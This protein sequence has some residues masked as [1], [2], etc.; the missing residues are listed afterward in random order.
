MAMDVTTL[1]VGGHDLHAV[2]WGGPGGSE[3]GSP[4]V[5]LVHGLGGSCIE[6]D[7]AAPLLAEALDRPVLALDLP[8]FGQSRLPSG[9]ATVLA[10]RHVVGEVM[11]E[12]GPAVLVGNSMGGLVGLSVAVAHPER[13]AGLVLVGPAL[14][15]GG[16]SMKTLRGALRFALPLMPGIGPR[17]IAARRR[18]LGPERHVAERLS[19]ILR[20]PDRVPGDLRRRMVE[21]ATERTAYA[22]AAAAYS[23]AARSIFTGANGFWKSVRE[24]TVPTLAVHGSHDRLVPVELVERL[25]ALRP[26]WTYEVVDDAGHLPHLEL[27][28]RFAE[29]VGSWIR[30][31]IA[32]G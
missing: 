4:S 24:V 19:A 13:V 2:R 23:G 7:L 25:R 32:P 18:R 1:R 21:Q 6:W 15:A 29:V 31:E 10:Y 17:I 9:P 5:L 12:L 30:A 3:G 11:E 16:F 22:E 26:D 14:S 8:G 27:P 28:D 20:D